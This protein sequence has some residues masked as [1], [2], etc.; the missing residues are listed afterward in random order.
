MESFG[1]D[2]WVRVGLVKF[3]FTKFVFVADSG[4]IAD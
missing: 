1:N 2:D 4:M 3:P